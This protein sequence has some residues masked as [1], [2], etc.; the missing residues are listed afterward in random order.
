MQALMA[1]ELYKY[2]RQR[3]LILLFLFFLIAP[4]LAA[5]KFGVSMG[6]ADVQPVFSSILT[7]MNICLVYFGSSSIS[8]EFEGKTIKNIVVLPNSRI[9]I[10]YTKYITLLAMTI[11]LHSFFFIGIG[12][13][14][15]I[16]ENTNTITGWVFFS[17]VLKSIT[18][19]SLAF[20]FSVCLKS[21]GKSLLL[22]LVIVLFGE[23]LTSL[24]YK[25]T[26][27]AKF[28]LLANYDL[29]K[30]HNVSFFNEELLISFSIL[31]VHFL[32]FNLIVL[33]VFVKTDI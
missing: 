21:T 28:S 18:F 14:E 17:L 10:I 13:S 32:I 23:N 30:Y 12:A 5:E 29:S 11:L 16:F 33:R 19:V 27:L 8:K 6:P 24:L 9:K 4:F 22:S 15:V 2:S 25:I 7:L 26:S 3:H 20:L 31:V 1:S